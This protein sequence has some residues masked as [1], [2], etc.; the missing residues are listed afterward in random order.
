MGVP[1]RTTRLLHEHDLAVLD[2]IHHVKLSTMPAA[3]SRVTKSKLSGWISHER[4]GAGETGIAGRRRR[5]GVSARPA[6][7]VPSP[8]AR[9]RVVP[10]VVVRSSYATAD[11]WKPPSAGSSRRKSRERDGSTACSPRSRQETSPC[12]RRCR[13]ARDDA[14][15]V[16]STVRTFP[17]VKWPAKSPRRLRRVRARRRRRGRDDELVQ[18]V[19][20]RS[21][22]RAA[23][24]PHARR[25]RSPPGGDREALLPPALAT[26]RR[27]RV[28]RDLDD[29]QRR[30]AGSGRITSCVWN[31]PS[32]L[33]RARRKC[34]R[35][36][37]S[38][39]CRDCRRR[40]P[41]PHATLWGSRRPC[42]ACSC[43]RCRAP[44][45]VY[46]H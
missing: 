11:G 5:G 2:R 39:R 46:K 31:V 12:V 38:R 6:D 9:R 10:T 27:I 7:T 43:R 28:A 44:C 45:R 32:P 21:G 25:T 4:P 41:R 37:W 35:P 42:G 24:R 26:R 19:E 18:L 34:C 36:R 15:Q 16:R 29:E 1:R 17:S 3:S 40:C 14:A 13:I 23:T 20:E 8:S 30:G 33:P 22:R